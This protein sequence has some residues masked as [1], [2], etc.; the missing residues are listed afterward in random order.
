MADLSVMLH[1]LRL[2]G[3]SHAADLIERLLA[4]R[5]WE[6][7]ADHVDPGVPVSIRATLAEAVDARDFYTKNRGRQTGV[8]RRRKAVPA[9]PWEVVPDV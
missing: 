1:G 5:E 9:G 7:G 2:R 6:Y 4:E 3:D 8:F